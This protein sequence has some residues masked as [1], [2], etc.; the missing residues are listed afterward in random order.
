MPAGCSSHPPKSP[1]TRPS[2]LGGQL[3]LPHTDGA[4]S[5]A[6]GLP[7]RP[8]CDSTCGHQC[9][10]T[11]V[12]T[13]Q[14]FNRGSIKVEVSLWPV[15]VLSWASPSS[16]ERRN[17]QCGPAGAGGAGS[18][19]CRPAESLAQRRLTVGSV[20]LN[21]LEQNRAGGVRGAGCSQWPPLPAWAGCQGPGRQPALARN[22]LLFTRQ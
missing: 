11:W 18:R 15:C 10:S 6:P 7:S 13:S 8:Q 2:A 12:V 14:G 16:S 4:A 22:G 19:G 20:K 17:V 3:H 9:K 5:S 21:Q 1:G